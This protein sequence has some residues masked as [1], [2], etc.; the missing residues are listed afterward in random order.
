[1][2]QKQKIIERADIPTLAVLI[3]ITV[4]CS[5]FGAD[6][7]ASSL[8][9]SISVF[10]L[11]ST[12]L[13]FVDQLKLSW[14]T[15]PIILIFIGF[16]GVHW[17]F[18]RSS[19]GA[20]EYIMVLSGGC[21]FWL[22]RYGALSRRRR[23]R[24]FK[25]IAVFAL[26]FSFLSF[27]QHVIAPHY[28]LGIE[29]TYHVDRLTGPFLS[30]NTTATFLGMLITFLLFRFLRA[31]QTGQIDTENSAVP[32]PLQALI[33]LPVTCS[34]L[35]VG[36]TCLLLTA[37]RA[38]FFATSLALLVLLVAF[39]FGKRQPKADT[40]ITGGLSV[41]VIAAAFLVCVI[42]IWSLSGTLLE[43]RMDT[44]DS[45]L[46]GRQIMLTASIEAG[47]LEPWLG[48]GL[49]GVHHATAMTSTAST[50]THIIT[51]NAS[52]NLF[53]QWFM[54]AGW[55][56]LVGLVILI[57]WIM[58]VT[59]FSSQDRFVK[60]FR[61]SLLSLVIAHGLFDYALEIPAVFLFLSLLVGLTSHARV[62]S[63][64]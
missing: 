64:H 49:N 50:N 55:P 52:H 45:D 3:V 57:V 2:S 11:F 17:L 32:A 59:L 25:I 40:P 27:F 7:P 53:A 38:G 23:R 26:F 33:S 24:I 4:A 31:F 47:K 20:H 39:L 1:M 15:F 37:S 51:Q 12:S 5:L 13:I 14:W 22:G 44:L 48:H 29:K 36:F 42:S 41:S 61:L 58:Q 21:V 56:G 54:Q 35:L 30:S 63:K 62:A 8:F 34:G 18:G 19:D 43:S 16:W 9:V 10:L 60:G 6:A 28:V 46:R